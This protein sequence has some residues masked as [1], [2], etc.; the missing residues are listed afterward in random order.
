MFSAALAGACIL[1]CSSLPPLRPD[2][3]DRAPR[4]D[5]SGKAEVGGVTLSVRADD[6]RTWISDTQQRA[7]PIEV[8]IHNGSNAPLAIRPDDF[9]LVLPKGARLAAIP[10]ARLQHVLGGLAVWD[11][12]S[13]LNGPSLDPL[14]GAY[15]PARTTSLYAW[16]GLQ[17][18]GP[19]PP[20]TSLGPDV[21]A[22][23]EGVLAPG[24]NASFLVFFDTPADKLSQ[25]TFEAALATESGAPLGTAR[26][27][28]AR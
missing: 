9:T 19:A 8:S 27:A 3:A 1:A 6:F 16:S 20:V 22:Q 25:F 17:G 14:T 7:T 23:P 26:L 13:P 5:T 11:G 4:A 2:E 15:D 28:F 10:P 12:R 24:R 18:R 21:R